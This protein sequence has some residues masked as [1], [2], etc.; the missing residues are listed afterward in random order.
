V[1]IKEFIIVPQN[2]FEPGYFN[3][4][5]TEPN[6][7]RTTFTCEGDRLVGFQFLAGFYFEDGFIEDEAFGVNS[8]IFTLTADAM[9]VQVA[10][11]SLQGYYS[12]DYFVNGYYEQ[13][14]SQFF[15]TAELEIVGEDVFAT[16]SWTNQ[17]A[18][19]ITAA[20]TVSATSNM[21]VTFVQ[22]ALGS[23]DR[24]I[25]LFAFSN[26]A[27][28]IQITVTRTTN[29]AVSSVFDIATDG[30]RF[31]DVAAAE[32]VLFDFDAIIERSREFNI[33]TQAAFSFNVLSTRIRFNNSNLISATELLA[34]ISHIEGADIVTN[35]FASLSAVLTNVRKEFGGSLVSQSSVYANG[36]LKLES[37][38]ALTAYSSIF[39]SRNAYNRTPI[40]IDGFPVIDNTFSKFGSSSNRLFNLRTRTLSY[41]NQIR[42]RI[43]NQ[44]VVEGW[45]LGSNFVSGTILFCGAGTSISDTNVGDNQW[46][47]WQQVRTVNNNGRFTFHLLTR[48]SSNQTVR[49]SS[50]EYNI[51]QLPWIKNPFT[52][53]ADQTAWNHIAVTKDANNLM[54]F[55][56]NDTV[57]ASGTISS[58]GTAS[59]YRIGFAG[60]K[61]PANAYWDEVSYRK[62]TSSRTTSAITNDVNNQV[63]LF[64]FEEFDTQI[65]IDDNSTPI[66]NHIGDASLTSAYTIDA[67]L[68]GVFNNQSNLQSISSLACTI[69]HIEGADLTAFS[70]AALTV[71]TLRIQQSEVSIESQSSLSSAVNKLTDI[72]SNQSSTTAVDAQAVVRRSAQIAAEAV[73]TQLTAV[74]RLAGLFVDD[75]VT[76]NLS[77]DAVVTRSAQL[78]QSAVFTQETNNVRLRFNSA[79]SNVV[80]NVV[81]NFDIRKIGEANLVSEFNQTTINDRSRDFNATC[82]VV[83]GITITAINLGKIEGSLFNE[84]TLIIEA[85]KIVNVLSNQNS[86]FAITSNNQRSRNV[87]SNLTSEFAQT[88]LVRKIVSIQLS[89]SAF[90]SKLTVAVKQ[91]VTDLDVYVVSTMSV[92]AV[93]TTKTSANCANTTTQSTIAVKTA[94]AISSQSSNFAQ[95]ADAIKAVFGSASLSVLAFNLTAAVK[96]AGISISTNTTATITVSAVKIARTS[97]NLNVTTNVVAPIRRIRPGRSTQSSNFTQTSRVGFLASAQV[98]IA[99]A[100]TFVS[101]VREIH[102][103]EIVYVIPGEIWEYDIN[104]ETRLHIIGSESREY[105]IT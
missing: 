35:G 30:R 65:P 60:T 95:T 85:V 94:R 2:Y 89:F 51:D 37:S 75:L 28:A 4:D 31:R 38:S 41:P 88:A 15:L 57:V 93:K 99:S 103:E 83:S 53:Q 71:Q 74:V 17:A 76:A 48:N 80:S 91:T 73:G 104:S 46:A 25:D 102:I 87:N 29:I 5:Y 105:I 66:I 24:D 33:E 14:G 69:S 63:F 42:A 72:T 19:A 70:N 27:I 64:H 52:N 59:E 97:S 8:V 20:K 84:A 79:S 81:V 92:S 47:I 32:D 43:T 55:Y 49:F 78:T 16:G 77:A 39:V 90:A 22:T 101:E 13:R 54:Q 34:I 23:R 11:V 45:Y 44:F 96:T 18:M 82:S 9:I 61:L 21:S 50:S 98:N 6:V 100:L 1:A 26:A 56:I 86:Q 58:L 10:T 62:G 68:S 36:G 40:V 3:G 67:R 12:Q 7:S